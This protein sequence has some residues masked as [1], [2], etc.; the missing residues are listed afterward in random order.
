MHH[1]GDQVISLSRMVAWLGARAEK[2][3]VQIYTGLAAASLIWE[4]GAVRG[5]KL[6][7]QGMDKDRKP[8][9]NFLEGEK[10][11]AKA[12]VLADGACGVLSREYITKIGGNKNPQVFSI[13]V[14]EVFCV[15]AENFKAG[16]VIHTL[17]FPSRLDVFG[18]GFYYSM[19]DGLVAIGLILGLDWCYSDLAPLKEF[20]IFK[21]HPFIAGLLK[22]ATRVEGGAT[23][24]PE[25]GYFSLPK[26]N[27]NGVVIIGDAAGFVNMEKIKGIHYGILSGMAAADAI[28]SGDLALYEQN[29]ETRGVLRDMRHARNFRAVFQAGLLAGAPLSLVQS[30][31]PWRIPMKGDHLAM[32]EGVCLSRGVVPGF[33]RAVFAALSGTMH[34]EDEPSHLIITDPAVCRRCAKLFQSPCTVFCP[35]EVYSRKGE[36]IRISATN[37]IHC[38]T[39]AIKCPLHNIVWTPPEGGEGPRYKTM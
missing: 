31:W 28:L 12:T 17:G 13:G 22:G 9:S 18:G 27:A 7:D 30:L 23:T 38:G 33:D 21:T 6:V 39:C 20:E 5:V 35:T 37:C 8:K 19:G 1:K 2:E 25:G 36:A 14:K 24:I 26:L 16:R 29:L 3:G 32:K 34:R 4:N 15:P 10:I 11:F